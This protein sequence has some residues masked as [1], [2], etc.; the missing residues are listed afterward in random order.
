MVSEG[1]CVFRK[2]LLVHTVV[3]ICY[4]HYCS[5]IS[6]PDPRLPCGNVFVSWNAGSIPS[7]GAGTRDCSQTVSE[8]Y[9]T[10]LGS[11]VSR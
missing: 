9:S 8:F 4:Q 2:L 5:F 3:D 11:D 1:T 7:F 10:G 6:S